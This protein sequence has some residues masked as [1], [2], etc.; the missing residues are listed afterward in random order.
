MSK[1]KV[2]TSLEDAGFCRS[3]KFGGKK[4]PDNPSKEHLSNT[5]GVL[6]KVPFNPFPPVKQAQTPCRTLP[7]TSSSS[8]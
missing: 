7:N 3:Y 6:F 5:L 4:D 1:R 2:L 8:T